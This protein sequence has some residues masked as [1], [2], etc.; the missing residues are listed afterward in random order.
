ME[1]K[2]VPR[3]YLLLIDESLLADETRQFLLKHGYGVVL[4]RVAAEAYSFVDAVIP[5]LI[6]VRHHPPLLDAASMCL[7]LRKRP[8]LTTIPILVLAA[9]AANLSDGV[10]W[11]NAGATAIIQTMELSGLLGPIQRHL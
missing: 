2:R 8:H 7:S 9:S 6:L 4:F 3:D 5:D 1:D 11:L 10:H